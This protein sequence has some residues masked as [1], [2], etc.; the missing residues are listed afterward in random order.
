MRDFRKLLAIA[1]AAVWTALCGCAPLQPLQRSEFTRLCMGVQTHITIFAPDESAAARGA[2]AAFDEIAR[3]AA[4]LCLIDWRLVELLPRDGAAALKK[5]GMRLDLGGIA[6][7][8]AADRALAVL[9]SENLPRSLV[10]IAGDI[11]A[12]DNPPD[13]DGWR[14]AIV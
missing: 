11:A 4:A 13:S 2:A 6:K 10:A 14:V 8:Y 5:P 3:L 1:F 9:R 12:G 7:C